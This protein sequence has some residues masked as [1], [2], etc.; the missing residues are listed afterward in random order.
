MN[1]SSREVPPGSGGWEGELRFL[2]MMIW[3]GR[4]FGQHKLGLRRSK[5]NAGSLQVHPK[6]RKINEAISIDAA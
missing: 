6:F 2:E 4:N 3:R 5:S 1:E